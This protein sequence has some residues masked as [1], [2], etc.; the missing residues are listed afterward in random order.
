LATHGLGDLAGRDGGLHCLTSQQLPAK[1]SQR[2]K[3]N[4]PGSDNF[5]AVPDECHDVS[6]FAFEVPVPD[7]QEFFFERQEMFMAGI[8]KIMSGAIEANSQFVISDQLDERMINLLRVVR[9][10]EMQEFMSQ[11]NGVIVP[12]VF[13]MTPTDRPNARNRVAR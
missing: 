1:I 9:K 2:K 11:I 6:S 13:R 3:G 10:Q 4:K 7:R 5:A 12:E 8:L